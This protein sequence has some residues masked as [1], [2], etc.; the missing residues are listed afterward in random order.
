MKNL[1]S[2]FIKQFFTPLFVMNKNMFSHTILMYH[3]VTEKK[4]NYNKRHQPK[5]DFIKHLQFLKK[6]CHVIPLDDFFNQK[7]IQSF[8]I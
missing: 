1:K 2:A 8:I 4:S 3:G 7:F 5:K 6:Y